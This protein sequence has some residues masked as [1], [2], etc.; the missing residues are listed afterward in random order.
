LS[1]IENVLG[2]VKAARGPEQDQAMGL[3]KMD[4]RAGIAALIGKKCHFFTTYPKAI[5]SSAR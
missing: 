3:V 1:F 5:C 2:Q 4:D